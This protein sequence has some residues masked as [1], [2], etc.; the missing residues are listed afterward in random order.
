MKKLLDYTNKKKKYQ[1]EKLER[2]YTDSIQNITDYLDGKKIS[3][4]SNI[5][6]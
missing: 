6:V 3:C 1:I 2:H 5:G 4:R